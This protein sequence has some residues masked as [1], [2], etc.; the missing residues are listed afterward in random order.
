VLDEPVGEF[1]LGGLTQAQQRQ[2]SH[3]PQQSFGIAH[4]MPETEDGLTIAHLNRCRALCRSA[5]LA[6]CHAFADREGNPTREDI[7]QALN[8][9]SSYLYILMLEEKTKQ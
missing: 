4:F 5:E 9:M 3:F 8:R 2:Q 6:A 1:T 7:L